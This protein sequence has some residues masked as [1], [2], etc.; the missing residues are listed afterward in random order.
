[1]AGIFKAYDV[2]GIYG[3]TLTDDTAYR[4]GRA[5]ATY[6]KPR[7]VVV[8]YDMRPHSKALF[9]KLTL[10]LRQQGVDVIDIGLVST[11]MCYYANGELGADGSVI[12][13]ASHNS[14]E[15]NGFKMC[16]HAAIPLS[17]PE[18]IE[19]IERIVNEDAYDDP[20]AEMGALSTHDVKAD[21][22]AAIREYADVKKPLKVAV[23]YANAMGIA[24]GDV[25]E[26][27]FEIVPLFKEYDGRFPNH[28]A[29]P[30]K[31]ETMEPLQ[32]KVREEGCD[33]GIAFDGDAD[34]AGFVDEH[35]DVVSMDKIT[36]LIAESLLKR[37]GGGVIFYDLRSSKAVKEIIEESGGEARMSRVGHAFIKNQMREAD[38]LFAGELSG[39][40]YFREN[41]F[42]ECSSLAAIHIA[43]LIADTGKTLSQLIEPVSRYCASGEINSRVGDPDE[44]LERLR[45]EYGTGKVIELDGL[46]F[47]FDDF[48]FNVRKS[49]TEPLVRLNL[50]ART[51]EMMEQK[52]DEVLAR[53]RA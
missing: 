32:A 5:F 47:E 8:G 9:D 28:E 2:R 6:L 16:R 42:A 52:R 11:P 25:L 49:N 50:E 1:M 26:G 51:A 27:L 24:E 23:D 7:K 30:L 53:I 43:N 36:A 22:I 3:D 35:G 18:G 20:A 39:H 15:W 34:R 19:D 33:F 14:Q 4:I 48:W 21:Y 41:Y 37:K 13:T 10:G 44:V 12:I 31:L 17:G 46:S 29:N 45:A 38:A 40:Y